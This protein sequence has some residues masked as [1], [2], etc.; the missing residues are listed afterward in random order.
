MAFYREMDS[1]MR[2]RYDPYWSATYYDDVDREDYWCD[3]W[4]S[5]YHD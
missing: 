3:Y 5:V 4:R 1:P 2:R